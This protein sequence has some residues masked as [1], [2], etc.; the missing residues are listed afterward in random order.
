MPRASDI[1]A[2]DVKT[3]FALSVRQANRRSDRM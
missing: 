3:G 1:I 2:T